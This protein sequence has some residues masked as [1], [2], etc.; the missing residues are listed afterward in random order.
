[1]TESQMEANL[2]TEKRQHK[3]TFHHRTRQT[4][5]I[6]LD[7]QDQ[8]AAHLREFPPRWPELGPDTPKQQHQ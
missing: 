4:P 5:K 6:R 7:H 1:M 8:L 2:F 3:L